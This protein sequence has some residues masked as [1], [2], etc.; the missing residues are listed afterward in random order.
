MLESLVSFHCSSTKP[1]PT[2]ALSPV[3]FSGTPETVPLNSIKQRIKIR[4]F[5]TSPLV[6]LTVKNIYASNYYLLMNSLGFSVVKLIPFIVLALGVIELL[7]E[8]IFPWNIGFAV[9]IFLMAALMI[10]KAFI[11]SRV[12]VEPE[13]EET[14]ETGMP[15]FQKPKPRVTPAP[16]KTEASKIDLEDF[17][18]SSPDSLKKKEEEEE[19]LP[20]LEVDEEEFETEPEEKLEEEPP[21][22]T[23]IES[24]EEKKEKLE[25]DFKAPKKED[26]EKVKEEALKELKSLIKKKKQSSKNA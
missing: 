25:K 5:I 12:A 26:V 7:H 8:R 17:L 13:R 18:V 19:E 9:V 15:S 11:D 16:K 4:R 10:K 23:G 6:F 24:V 22:K 21:E 1:F 14:I 2:V 3:G 20:E